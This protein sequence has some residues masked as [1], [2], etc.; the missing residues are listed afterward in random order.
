MAVLAAAPARA[1]TTA[2]AALG[3]T[4][5]YRLELLKLKGHLQVARALLQQRKPGAGHHLQA[6]FEAIFRRIE[7]MLEARGAPLSRDTLA[8]LDRAADAPP[9]TALTLLDDAASAIDGS[10][11]QPGPL[12]PRSALALS[13]ALLKAAVDLY[14]RAVEDNAVNDLRAYQTGRGFVT[15][16][17]ALV[18]HATGLSGRPG[19]ETLLGSVVLIRQAWPGVMPPPIVFD[20]ASV[21]Q[22]LEEALAAMD[23]LE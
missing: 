7:P 18:R 11:A 13:R 20:P 4:D 2:R 22:R 8:Q 6:P 21:A 1:D 5:A 19:H 16:A 10:F 9:Q 3:E 17:E 23:A 15:Q 14:A 12:R